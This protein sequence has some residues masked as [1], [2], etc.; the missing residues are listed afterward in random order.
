M[1]H[2]TESRWPGRVAPGLP[3]SLHPCLRPSIW[4]LNSSGPHRETHTSPSALSPQSSASEH[5]RQKIGPAVVPLPELFLVTSN[6]GSW[7]TNCT[8]RRTP[9]S[10][11]TS[12]LGTRAFYASTRGPTRLILFPPESINVRIQVLQLSSTPWLA[13][14]SRTL[15]QSFADRTPAAKALSGIAHNQ[16]EHM[17]WEYGSEKDSRTSVGRRC[18]SSHLLGIELHHYK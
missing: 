8:P 14:L 18:L 1:L 12:K 6:T 7:S 11:F 3:L 4:V 16:Y 13:E 5:A 17:Q 9:W 15:R 10:Q 2:W